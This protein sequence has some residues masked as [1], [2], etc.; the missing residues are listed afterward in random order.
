MLMMDVCYPTKLKKHE[1]SA[2]QEGVT[3]EKYFRG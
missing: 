3:Q 1:D 2:R